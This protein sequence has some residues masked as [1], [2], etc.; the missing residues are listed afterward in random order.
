MGEAAPY[1]AGDASDA[2]S[3]ADALG[4]GTDLVGVASRDREL[5]KVE[6]LPECVDPGQLQLHTEFFPAGTLRVEAVLR[7]DLHTQRIG[8]PVPGEA[9]M[10]IIHQRVTIEALSDVAINQSGRATLQRLDPEPGKYTVRARLDGNC[11]E[12]KFTVPGGEAPVSTVRFSLKRGVL[13]VVGTARN[14]RIVVRHKPGGTKIQVVVDGKVKGEF[15]ARDVARFKIQGGAGDDLLRNKTRFRSRM[16]G[17]PGDDSIFG[18]RGD[19]Q[20]KGGS[21]DD[22]VKGGAGNDVINGGPGQDHLEGGLGRDTISGGRGEDDLFGDAG[23]DTLEGGAGNDDLNGGR[24]SDNLRGGPGDDTLC[25]GGDG[26]FDLDSLD[27]GSGAD[28]A[29]GASKDE[30][31]VS[32]RVERFRR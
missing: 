11:V 27:G 18:G 9:R 1:R 13:K 17:G 3:I 21:G 10:G 24:Q 2:R 25:A 23:Q 29:R 32:H 8:V 20:V 31:R 28:T 26:R 5:A 4:P 16:D 22:L 19:D 14:D 15:V 6:G 12:Q 30:R 7:A